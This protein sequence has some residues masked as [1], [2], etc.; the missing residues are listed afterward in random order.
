[1]PTDADSDAECG[2]GDPHDPY[3]CTRCETPIPKG[4]SHG[5]I[6]FST[7]CIDCKSDFEEAQA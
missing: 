1:M 7:V 3:V 6:G 2:T 4:T 5:V